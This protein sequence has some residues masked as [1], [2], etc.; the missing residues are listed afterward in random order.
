MTPLAP[1]TDSSRGVGILVTPGADSDEWLS[2]AL[3]FQK[4][5]SDRT[6]RIS[7]SVDEALTMDVCDWLVVLT[8]TSEAPP[9]FRANQTRDLSR[10]FSRCAER[11]AACSVL[12][13]GGGSRSVKSAEDAL[14]RAGQA[15]CRLPTGPVKA[16]ELF[17]AAATATPIDFELLRL[18]ERRLLADEAFASFDLTG[19]P[20]VLAW[21]PHMT[22]PPGP[23]RLSIGFDVDR[24]AA[25]QSLA[26]EWGDLERHERHEVSLGRAGRYDITLDRNWEA[27][28]IAE[29]RVSAA[30]AI[31]AGRMRLISVEI[32]R[33]PNE[34]PQAALS[35]L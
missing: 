25:A 35:Q 14:L 22:L 17:G 34:R 13:A 30:H 20:D 1:S 29:F 7:L 8:D 2:K 24:A 28:A 16:L 9:E 12:G 21:G 15:L 5:T 11:G 33:T 19:R 26:F 6:V 31:F 3:T 4:D 27:A 23:W 10:L 32:G 18:N